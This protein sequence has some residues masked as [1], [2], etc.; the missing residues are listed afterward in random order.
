MLIEQIF[1]LRRSWLPG[2][3]YTP[4]TDCFHDKTISKENLRVDNYILLKYSRRNVPYFP[5]LGPN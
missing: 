5:L 1:E 3:T 2:R 4:L